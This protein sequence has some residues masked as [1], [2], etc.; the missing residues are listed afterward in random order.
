MI[1]CL[2]IATLITIY[3]FFNLCWAD[4]A[5]SQ[6]KDVNAFI[7]QMVKK[8]H[9]KKANLKKLFA[10]VKVRK[11]VLEYFNKPFE[12]KPWSTYRRLFVDKKRID[13]GVKF[14][15]K[16]AK[17][18]AR[19]QKKYGVDPSIIV[20]TLGVETRY[21]TYTGGFRV[22]DSLASLGFTQSRRSSFFR[23]ELE[24][25]LLLTREQH[26]N[27]LEVTG[28]YAGA[29]GVPQFMPS[30]YRTYAVDYTNNGSANLMDN[31]DDIISSVA[32]YYKRKGW[33]KDQ[34]VAVPAK[35]DEKKFAKLK[36]TLKHKQ[37]ISIKTLTTTHSHIHP[38]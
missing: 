15:D 21:G 4:T 18:L 9:F 24:Q 33:K 31:T 13:N 6:R 30:S 38:I 8:H 36:K 23:K 1:R 7:D 12:S 28:S 19:A 35:V 16:H 34:P 32:N 25:F 27:P 10:Q 20:A 2:L 11:K 14:W 37:N 29:I 5:L 22:I 3:T 26:L 17:I